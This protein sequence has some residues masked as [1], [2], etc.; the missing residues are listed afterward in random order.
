MAG[1]YNFVSP[2]AMAGGAIEQFFVQRAMEERQA[3]LDQAQQAEAERRATLES[4]RLALQQTEHADSQRNIGNEF[5]RRTNLDAQAER[6]RQTELNKESDR[7]NARKMLAQGAQAATT[8]DAM[9]TIGIQA[10][11]E[12]LE[13]KPGILDPGAEARERTERDALLH[14][15]ELEQIAAQGQQS[16]LTAGSRVDAA[17]AQQEWVIRNGQPTPIAR[18]TA[19]AGDAPYDPVAARQTNTVDP[20]EAEDTTRTALE[21][22]NRLDT[23]PGMGKA[24][25]AYEWRGFTQE[26]TDFNAIRNQLVAALA[27]PNL[28][29]LK[30]PMSDKDILFVKQLATRLENPRLSEDETRRAIQEARAFLQNKLGAGQAAPGVVQPASAPAGGGVQRWGRG[31]DGRPVRLQ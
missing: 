31:P 5:A 30:G 26:A 21:L 6:D 3:M 15:Q 20:K 23:H 1:R 18:G 24:T 14:Q 13:L 19:Q 22:T 2:G 29:A 12:G 25:G 17:P 4:D 28:G 11:G 9:R 7:A 27:L 16:R 10:F 8:P